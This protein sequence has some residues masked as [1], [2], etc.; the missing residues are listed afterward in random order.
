MF[1]EREK[2]HKNDE[3]KNEDY[4]RQVANYKECLSLSLYLEITNDT[5]KGRGNI[6]ENK[7][8]KA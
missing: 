8:Y 7:I 6:K 3:E 5:V 4:K 1:F 2:R